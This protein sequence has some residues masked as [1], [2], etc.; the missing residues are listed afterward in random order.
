VS[1]VVGPF[2]RWPT[3]LG[4]DDFYGFIGGE[5]HQYYPVLFE[6]TRPVEHTV[7]GRFGI[8]TFGIGCDTGSSVSDGYTAPFAFTGAIGRVDIVLGEP[9]LDPA[10][11]AEVHARFKAGK[12]Y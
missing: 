4:F 10:E 8:D 1:S 2:D 3:G 6:N 7:A 5:T 11:E 9:G 12:D